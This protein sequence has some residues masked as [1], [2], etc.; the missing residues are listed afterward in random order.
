[1]VAMVLLLCLGHQLVRI[2]GESALQVLFRRWSKLE[3]GGGLQIRWRE[4]PSLRAIASLPVAV[5]G[6][7]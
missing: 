5:A 3:L 2:E 6:P 1:M 7:Q 4:L